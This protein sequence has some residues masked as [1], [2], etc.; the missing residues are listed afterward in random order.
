M[1]VSSSATSIRSAI[2]SFSFSDSLLAAAT[3]SACSG[4]KCAAKALRERVEAAA[5]LQQRVAQLA[6]GDG[7]ELG[8]EA[9]G[10]LQGGDVFKGGDGAEQA[11]FGVAHGRGAQAVAALLLADAHG[12]HGGFVFGGHRLLHGDGVADGAQNLVAAGSVGEGHA[13]GGGFAQHFG[14]G[15]VHLEHVAL[16][17]GDD[18]GLKDGLQHGVGELKLH[19]PA[20]GLGVAQVA[21]ADRDAVQFAGDDAEVVAAAPLHAVLQVALGDLL[22][23]A[24]Q[25]V[26]GAGGRGRWLQSRS[27]PRQRRRRWPGRTVP[28][29]PGRCG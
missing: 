5:Q 4:C 18:D 13:V 10:V 24:G 17:V 26:D 22:C 23:V 27:A 12:Q 14:R 7:D 19:L 6:A 16:A 21:Q 9:V 8:L 1:P 3:S 25:H 11:A 2:R 29:P 28:P 20:A 15:L